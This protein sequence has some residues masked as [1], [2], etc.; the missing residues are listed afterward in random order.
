MLDNIGGTD[1]YVGNESFAVWAASVGGVTDS[2]VANY[3]GTWGVD[4]STHQVWAIVNH[5]SE[6]A[7]VPEPGTL[8]LLATA[9]LGLV[10]Y[11]WRKRK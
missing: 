8:V 4:T 11:G 9:L 1:S 5:N 7:V 10:A 3:L 2:N 6:F